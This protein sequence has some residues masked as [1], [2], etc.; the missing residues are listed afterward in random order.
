M[1][2]KNSEAEIIARYL[3]GITPSLITKELYGKGL[4]TLN[5]S[6]DPV[7]RRIWEICMRYPLTLPYIDSALAVRDPNNPI[8]KR[9]NLM[10]AILET[11]P[12]LAEKFLKNHNRISWY[13][14]CF[15]YGTRA[16]VRSVIGF[17]LI[18]FL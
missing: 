1:G 12:L 6:I 4:R 15:F 9:I 11:D 16:I 10:F 13:L 18:K 14:Q 17:I 3:L 5:L 8:R 7:N 2:A